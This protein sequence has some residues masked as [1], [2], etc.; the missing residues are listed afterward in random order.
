MRHDFKNIEGKWQAKWEESKLFEAVDF[1]V[2]GKESVGGMLSLAPDTDGT[3]GFF[4]AH[5]RK[6]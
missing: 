4:I 5:M 2:G 6:K 1:S 3:D